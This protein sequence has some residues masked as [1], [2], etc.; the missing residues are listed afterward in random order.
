VRSSSAGPWIIIAGLVV[1]LI[2]V[3]VWAGA[4]SWFG[5]LPGDIRMERESVR[6]YFPL[7]SMLVLSVVISVVFYLINRFL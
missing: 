1:V 6:V 7:V 5:R 3:A 2:G 4:L